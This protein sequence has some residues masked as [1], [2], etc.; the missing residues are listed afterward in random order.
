MFVPLLLRSAPSSPV[1]GTGAMIYVFAGQ[2]HEALRYGQV[3]LRLMP[4]YR[5]RWIMAWVAAA[6][7]LLGQIEEAET[8]FKEMA[9]GDPGPHFAASTKIYLSLIEAG[10]GHES[11]ARALVSQALELAPYLSV[12]RQ[13]GSMR[14]PAL[15]DAWAETWR[16]LG[17]PE[18]PPGPKLN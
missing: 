8:L 18:N 9:D 12:G 3:A 16:R 14:Q 7:L 5:L 4:R 6:Y 11:R 17:L 13:I 1:V 2:P 10:R 15:L